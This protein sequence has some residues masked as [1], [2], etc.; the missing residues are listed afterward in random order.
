MKTYSEVVK[1]YSQLAYI[2]YMNGSSEFLGG[3]VDVNMVVFIYSVPFE[4][5][6]TDIR[7]RVDQIVNS[8]RQP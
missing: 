8:G 4:K 5:V 3:V 1:K 7:Q 6:V 2:A